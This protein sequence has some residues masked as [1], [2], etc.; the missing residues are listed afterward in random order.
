M[1]SAHL[2]YPVLILRPNLNS[3]LT[4]DV[5]RG[6]HDVLHGVRDVCHGDHDDVHGVRGAYEGDVYHAA[7]LYDGHRTYHNI[8]VIKS[9][10]GKNP[11]NNK[12]S[13]RDPAADLFST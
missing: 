8:L 9:R 2:V 3:S 5:P 4:Y 6:D 7:N 13:Y 12:K 11:Y 1:P 10:R